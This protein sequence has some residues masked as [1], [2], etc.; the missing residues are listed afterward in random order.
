[1]KLLRECVDAFEGIMVIIII[2]AFFTIIPLIIGLISYWLL[3]IAFPEF[4][5]FGWYWWRFFALGLIGV[6]LF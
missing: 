3:A 6:I 4:I 1:M 2:V 5:S